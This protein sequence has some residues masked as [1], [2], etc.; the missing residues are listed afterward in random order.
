MKRS[1]SDTIVEIAGGKVIK[2]KQMK[3]SHY[4]VSRKGE[5]PCW[6]PVGRDT[7]LKAQGDP[8]EVE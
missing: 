7:M 3:W 4:Q 1:R 5:E 2:L 8:G 6:G